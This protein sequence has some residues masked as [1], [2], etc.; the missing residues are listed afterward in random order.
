MSSR[1]EDAAA[2]EGEL[3][4]IRRIEGLAAAS[5]PCLERVQDDGWQ[6]RYNGN[7]T[8][9]CSSV[10][11]SE[12]GRDDLRAKLERAEAFYRDH[13]SAPRFQLT[14]ASRPSGLEAALAARGY[15]RAPGAIVMT[16]PLVSV[17]A[18]QAAHLETLRSTPDLSDAWLDAL[19]AAGGQSETDKEVLRSTLGRCKQP[20]SFMLL[21]LDGVISAVALA[22][23][24]DGFVG[25]FNVATLPERRRRGAAGALMRHLA[26]WGLLRGCEEASLQV[27]PGNAAAIALYRR[28]GFEAHHSYA[29]WAPSD[30]RSEVDRSAPA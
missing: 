24:A 14:L 5:L 18:S 9:R 2:A 20:A 21:E 29:Y 1:P 6:L 19:V 3:V 10:L 25:A 27:H 22:V 4:R 7:V 17:L 23:A 8:R 12:A 16:A 11:A 13:G 28:C 30:A 15:V 26:A